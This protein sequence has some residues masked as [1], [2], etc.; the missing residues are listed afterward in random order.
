M[1]SY[2]ISKQTHAWYT[3]H[4]LMAETHQLLSALVVDGLTTLWD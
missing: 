2:S 3:S 1:I 4:A